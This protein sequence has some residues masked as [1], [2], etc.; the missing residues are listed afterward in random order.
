LPAQEQRRFTLKEAAERAGRSVTTLRRYVRAGRLRAEMT[1]GRFGP[2]YTLD[3][4]ALGEAGLP[5]SG[6]DPGRPR[7]GSRTALAPTGASPR[8]REWVDA[9]RVNGT[10][11]IEELLKEFVPADLY[12]ELSMKHE[13]LLVQYGMIRASGQRLFEIREEAERA[14]EELRQAQDRQKELQDRSSRE[15][16]FLRQH[17]RQAELEIEQRNMELLALREKVR[18]LELMTR[19]AITTESIEKQFLQIFEKEREIDAMLASAFHDESTPD[20]VAEQRRR[21]LQTLDRW[22]DPS[23]RQRQGHEKLEH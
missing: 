23:H 19:N 10:R 11:P 16:G 3:E 20:A 17:L 4:T 15:I 5:V 2:E 22:L 1:P 14:S 6:A 8:G 7:A 9:S 13:Q 12:R 18:I 21:A